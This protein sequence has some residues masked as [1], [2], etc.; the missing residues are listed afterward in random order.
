MYVIVYL[1][2]LSFVGNSQNLTLVRVEFHF[3]VEFPGLEGV[4]V[5]LQCGRVLFSFNGSI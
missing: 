5:P 3:V 4:E 2:W 1:D